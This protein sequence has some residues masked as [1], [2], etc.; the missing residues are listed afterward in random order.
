[1]QSDLM[2]T[3]RRPVQLLIVGSFFAF[4][5][6]ATVA[7]ISPSGLGSADGYHNGLMA[8]TDEAFQAFIIND[9]TGAPRWPD[10]ESVPREIKRLIVNAHMTS[11]PL[12][13]SN[14][15]NYFEN[16]AG[17][18]VVVNESDIRFRYYGSN[19]TFLGLDKPVIPRA[20]TS[21]TGPVYLRPGYST[22]LYAIENTKTLGALKNQDEQ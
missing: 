14:F 10:F 1:M 5:F 4:C 3:M 8:P 6:F 12:Y 22:F 20:F 18:H 2:N 17:D 19:C 21:I 11:F 16:A 7:R 9:L 13:P 15:G